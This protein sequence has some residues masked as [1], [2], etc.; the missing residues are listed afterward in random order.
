MIK[1]QLSKEDV[2]KASLAIIKGELV[3]DTDLLLL[4]SNDDRLVKLLITWRR[5]ERWLESVNNEQFIDNNDL[6]W[7]MTRFD[8]RQ[9][10]V[11]SGVGEREIFN[12]WRLLAGNR[13]LYPDGTLNSKIEDYLKDRYNDVIGLQ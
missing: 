1:K 9:W 6:A 3:E 5:V 4:L 10:S 8:E 13:F 7:T 2:F 12:L 11:L